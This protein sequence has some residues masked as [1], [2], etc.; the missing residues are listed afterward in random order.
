MDKGEMQHMRRHDP[1]APKEKIAQNPPKT[2]GK[3]RNPYDKAVNSFTAD[4]VEGRRLGDVLPEVFGD[5]AAA[6]EAVRAAAGLKIESSHAVGLSAR[7]RKQRGAA[8]YGLYVLALQHPDDPV[9][10]DNP[11]RL[12][13]F[14]CIDRNRASDMAPM[15]SHINAV[16]TDEESSGHSHVILFVLSLFGPSVKKFKTDED[17]WAHIWDTSGGSCHVVYKR[18]IFWETVDPD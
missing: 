10:E 6:D 17:G 8:L 18:D 1:K 4:N 11:R 15:R 14:E 2:D 3:I 9:S 13:L 12:V 16:L 5:E 7:P